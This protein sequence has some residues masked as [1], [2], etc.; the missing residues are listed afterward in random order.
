M[1]DGGYVGNIY[2]GTF[3]HNLGYAPMFIAYYAYDPSNFYR[4]LPYFP[5]LDGGGASI[6]QGFYAY[7]DA[8]NLYVRWTV[9]V[10]PGQF[11]QPDSNGPMYPPSQYPSG[12][13]RTFP[14]FLFKNPILTN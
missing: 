8:T 4:V 1:A 2:I 11:G 5:H 12:V 9:Y 13:S 3:A 14:F 6:K 10:L 7:A